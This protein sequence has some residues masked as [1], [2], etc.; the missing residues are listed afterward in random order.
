MEMDLIDAFNILEV[1]GKWERISRGEALESDLV[2]VEA[3]KW[4]MMEY[5]LKLKKDR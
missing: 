3:Q 4:Y 5:I 2:D 1:K